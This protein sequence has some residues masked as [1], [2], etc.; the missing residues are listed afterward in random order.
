M[1]PRLW[2]QT[3]RAT[4]RNMTLFS[5]IWGVEAQEF[6]WVYPVEINE[7]INLGRHEEA[8]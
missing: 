4:M 5:L 1:N 8:G 3:R 6:C 7:L 2:P